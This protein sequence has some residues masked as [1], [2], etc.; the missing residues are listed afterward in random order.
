MCFIKVNTFKLK[1][2]TKALTQRERENRSK[3][4]AKIFNKIISGDNSIGSNLG[5]LH[6]MSSKSFLSL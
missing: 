3:Q 2:N 6:K 5:K 1:K 4:T